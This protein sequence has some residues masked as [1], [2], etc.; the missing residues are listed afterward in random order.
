MVFHSF[1]R[2][3]QLSTGSIVGTISDPSAAV[4][5]GAKI[6]LT[7]VDT[8]QRIDVVTNSAG[9]FISGALIPGNYTIQ[10][11]AEGFKSAERMT[12]PTPR[13]SLRK[14][15]LRRRLSSRFCAH[16]KHHNDEA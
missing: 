4:I 13:R 14:N 1:S 5:S 10:I 3:R 15:A 11:S 12:I 8:R 6:I 7:N 9:S 2:L 16:E